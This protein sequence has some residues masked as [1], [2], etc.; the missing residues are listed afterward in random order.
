MNSLV[1]SSRSFQEILFDIEPAIQ[2]LGLTMLARHEIG[3]E[4][5]R[6][7]NG[8]DEDCAIIEVV[9]WRP[10]ESLL[11]LDPATALHLPWRIVVLTERGVTRLGFAP[12]PASSDPRVAAILSEIGMRLQQLVDEMR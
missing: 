10:V 4:L 3:S 6:R 8:F 7:D 11:A 2:R 12:L 5:A 1:E 9:G